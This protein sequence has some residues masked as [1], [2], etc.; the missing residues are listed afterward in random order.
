M[1]II[2]AKEMAVVHQTLLNVVA[3]MEFD[4]ELGMYTSNDALFIVLDE[5]KYNDLKR[6]IKKLGE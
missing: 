4:A 3:T 5:N 6:A 2:E 1:Q